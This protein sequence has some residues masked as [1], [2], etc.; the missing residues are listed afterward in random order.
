M[1]RALKELAVKKKWFVIEHD[2]AVFDYLSDYVHV[3][4]GQENAYGVVF[5]SEKRA[6]R[7]KRIP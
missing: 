7:D 4:Y 2:L 3:F 6:K 5:R 1:A